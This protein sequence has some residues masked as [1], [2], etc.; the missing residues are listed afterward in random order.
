[1]SSVLSYL[2]PQKLA[3]FSTKY[4]KHIRVNDE[5]G[6]KKLLVNGSVQSGQY[7]RSLWTAAFSKFG[8]TK[9][10]AWKNILVLGVGGGTVIE[11]LHERFPN[12]HITAVDIDPVIIDIAKKYFLTGDIGYIEFVTA[13]ARKFIRDTRSIYDCIIIDI[14]IGNAIPEFVKTK[15]F[16]AS[17][18]THVSPNGAVCINYLQEREYGEKSNEVYQT[19][20]S[21]FG[22]V[23]D[24]RKAFNR[25]FNASI[26]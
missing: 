25:F 3:E 17:C 14:F 6:K 1:V 23:T 22:H 15:A 19:L 21:M 20:R 11:L 2:V 13:D 8:I 7:I 5:Y 12:A 10:T 4:N 16:L 24:F 9:K 18:K 26:V